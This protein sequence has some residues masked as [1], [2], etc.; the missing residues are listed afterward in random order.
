MVVGARFKTMVVSREIEVVPIISVDHCSPPLRDG[1]G[2]NT[3]IT[4][5]V[6]GGVMTLRV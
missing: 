4:T 2:Q 3:T 5:R 1:L 6:G